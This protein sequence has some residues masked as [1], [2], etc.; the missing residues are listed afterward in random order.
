MSG[1]KLTGMENNSKLEQLVS[2]LAC[3]VN[4][5]ETV[6]DN[7]EDKIFGRYDIAIWKFTGILSIT[8]II[9]VALRFMVQPAGWYLVD[10]CS[11]I[12]LVIL[13]YFTVV[14]KLFQKK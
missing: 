9:T 7:A 14:R 12:M 1:L 8:L 10:L 6:S 3:W 13:A 2:K 4:D 11:V 5:N